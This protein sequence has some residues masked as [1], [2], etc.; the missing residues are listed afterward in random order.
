MDRERC[1]ILRADFQDAQRSVKLY[2]VDP[3]SLMQSGAYRYASLATLEDR[4][5]GSSV[6][7]A[8]RGVRVDD[9]LSS[10]YFD[11]RNFYKL[12]H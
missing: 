5:N 11:P 6:K 3:A 2:Q 7:L 4:V 12:D 9:K 1:V 8:L 10:R